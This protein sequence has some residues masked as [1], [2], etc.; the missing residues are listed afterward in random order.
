[1]PIIYCYR[2]CSALS[3]ETVVFLYFLR[4]IV[5][6]NYEKN[7]TSERKIFLSIVSTCIRIH[8]LIIKYV[9]FLHLGRIFKGKKKCMYNRKLMILL[10]W[11]RVSI[12]VWEDVWEYGT[13][14]GHIVL[15]CIGIVC[16]S[17]NHLLMPCG[18]FYYWWPR[19]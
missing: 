12:W 7:S 19:L 18:V 10:Y 6:W 1:M 5:I 2:F 16:I 3:L 17:L 9:V 8:F 14:W 13:R 15:H 11:G 4:Y